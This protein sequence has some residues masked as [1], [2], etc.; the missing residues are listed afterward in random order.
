MASPLAA[1]EPRL[2]VLRARRNALLGASLIVVSAVAFSAKA[3][4]AKLGY[5]AGADPATLLSLRMALSMPFFVIAALITARGKPPLSQCD[6]AKI[7][8][9]GVLGYYLAS[10]LDFY[11][12]LYVSAGLER[13]I[14]F[15]YP[16][17]VVLISALAYKTP[18]TRRIALALLLTY[19][20]VAFAV[21]SEVEVAEG[22]DVALGVIL[23]LGCALTYALYLVGSGQLIPRL[24]S[25]RFTALAML[26][27]TAAMLIHFTLVGGSFFG[28]SS[29]VYLHGLLLALVCTVIP[30][31]LLAEGIRRIGAGPA[32]IIGAVGPISTVALA[33]V[34]LG[35][36]L[37]ASQGVGT[38]L[39]LIGAT[40][41]AR[42]SAR[43]GARHRRS[44][45]SA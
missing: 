44:R 1:G 31:F 41:V 10:V 34:F 37:H 36:P 22:P 39:V 35:E 21:R 11:G 6:L 26:V 14:L 9:L 16:T 33:Y 40:L 32:S 38:L 45:S 19:A 25:Q 24:G 27:S 15:I 3:I 20:G 42:S 18:I 2:S 8:L 5:R 7:G 43:N 29:L 30:V 4:I 13:L 28:H 17:L 12:L 23:V